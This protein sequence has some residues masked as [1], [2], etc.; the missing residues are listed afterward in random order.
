[1]TS[2]AVLLDSAVA[3]YAFGGHS[4]YKASC[5]EVMRRIAEDELEAYGSV[6]MVQEFVHHRLRRTGD[7]IGAVA[8]GHD[9]AAMI[10]LLDFDPAVL[11][12]ALDL[13]GRIRTVRGR[14]AVHAATA[15]LYGI[16]TIISPDPAF[17]GIGG[18]VRADPRAV[19]ASSDL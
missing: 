5:A 10:K 7:H 17:D 16:G 14:D 6:E 3:L 4:S 12:L 2:N 13:I 11:E 19:A 1:V 18:I 8:D 9:L 15:L